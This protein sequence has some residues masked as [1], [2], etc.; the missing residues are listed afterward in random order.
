MSGS[1]KSLAA[2]ALIAALA[3]AFALGFYSSGLNYP[4]QRYQP[5]QSGKNDKERTESSISDVATTIVKRTPCKQPQSESESDLCA[6]WRAAKAAEKSADWAVYGFWATLAGMALLTWQIMLT[7]EAVNDTSEATAAMREA[8]RIA[9]LAQR[10]WLTVEIVPKAL[11]R[12]D[13]AIRCDIDVNVKN[14]GQS[15]AKNYCLCFRL[16]YTPIG[17][18]DEVE[19][20]WEEFTSEKDFNRRVVLPGDTETFDYWQYKR[21]DDLPWSKK[22][23]VEQRL[24][25]MFVVS[26]FYQSDLTGDDWH[27]V[28]K[29]IWISRRMENGRHDATITRDFSGIESDRLV[30]EPLTNGTLM[31]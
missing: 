4:D 31:S 18:F 25:V 19:D 10:P 16:K 22:S 1:Y 23:G 2:T 17:T 27:R 20:I 7:R 9:L 28:D 30:G 11:E 26:V 13:A 6:Q 5:Y 15:V 21:F 14:L 12:K 3:L 24:A 29:A 8:N